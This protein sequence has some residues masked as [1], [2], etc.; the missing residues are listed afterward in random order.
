MIFTP[1]WLETPDGAR[2]AYHWRPGHGR[3]LVLAH[4]HS[5]TQGFF[6][7]LISALPDWPVLIWDRRG[8]G[9]SSRGDA[10]STSPQVA[11]LALLLDHLGLEVVDLMGVAA[12]GAVVVAC[13]AQHPARVGA[14]IFVNSFMGL[15]AAFWRAATAEAPPQGDTAAQ[16]LSP[17]FASRPAAD[18]WRQQAAHNHAIRAGEPPQPSRIQLPDLATVAPLHIWTGALD[19][20]FTPA[21][22]RHAATLLPHAK[23]QIFPGVA[24]ASPLEDPATV[25]A[26]LRACL[27][28]G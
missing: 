19:L 16:E 24:H 26:A 20:L 21:M 3:P 2:L 17:D 28:R 22:C 23:T 13:A 10:Y 1:N 15:P 12:G 8:Y 5:A 27:S 25:A 4:P 18:D 11:D 14:A 7:P 6:V 9:E